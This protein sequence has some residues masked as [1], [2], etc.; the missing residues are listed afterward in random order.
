MSMSRCIKI[1]LRGGVSLRQT[2]KRKD[3]GS[4]ICVF[5][6]LG[7]NQ[8]CR[9]ARYAAHLIMDDQYQFVYQEF[10]LVQEHAHRGQFSDKQDK[11][12]LSSAPPQT[13]FALQMQQQRINKRIT[14]SELAKRCDIATNQLSAFESGTE[15]PSSSLAQHILTTL[16]Q[17]RS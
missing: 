9:V 8:I 11:R 17:G 10:D 5:A 1:F 14:I 16:E 2:D 6:L 15:V 3:S 13:S 7:C 12:H 4:F